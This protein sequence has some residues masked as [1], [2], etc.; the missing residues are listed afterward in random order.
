MKV[1]ADALLFPMQIAP[2]NDFPA[3]KD[4][5]HIVADPLHKFP[6]ENILLVGK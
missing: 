4:Y 1:S 2:K 3:Q 6:K 5:D